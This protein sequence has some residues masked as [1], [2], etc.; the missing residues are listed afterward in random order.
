[1][2]IIVTIDRLEGEMAI[3]RLN[4]GQEINLPISELPAGAQE[5]SKL[6]MS[7][8]HLAEEESKQIERARQLLNDLL[9]RRGHNDSQTEN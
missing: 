1:M 4:D 2:S 8:V 7:L 3:I 5:G 6:A 9:Q